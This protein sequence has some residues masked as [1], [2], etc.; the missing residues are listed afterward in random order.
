[1]WTT[2]KLPKVADSVDE[3][4]VQE[5]LVSPGQTVAP[6]DPILRVETDKTVV[7]VPS[8]VAGRVHEVLVSVDDEIPTGTAIVVVNT[9]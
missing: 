5:V 1:M 4:L 3:V 7:E 2:V 6:G 9:G 8:P